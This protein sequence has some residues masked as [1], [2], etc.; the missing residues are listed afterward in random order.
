MVK[1]IFSKSQKLLQKF[2]K[3]SMHFLGSY[4]NLELIIYKKE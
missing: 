2:Y 1:L 4:D 3:Y